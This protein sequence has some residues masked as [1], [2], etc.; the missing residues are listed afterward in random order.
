V[1]AAIAQAVGRRVLTVPMPPPAAFGVA[2][3]DSFVSGLRRT[4]PLITRGRIHELMAHDWSC[5]ISRARE[6]LGFTPSI[7]LVDGMR[8]TCA[9]YRAHGWLR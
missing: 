7:S 3:I 9:W 2:T 4:K 5:D 8:E 1:T 6:E